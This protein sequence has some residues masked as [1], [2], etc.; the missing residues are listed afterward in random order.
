LIVPVIQAGRCVGTLDIESDT[1]GAFGGAEI[2]QYEETAAVLRP[3]W[4]SAQPDEH[5]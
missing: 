5:S 1:V 3:L 2:T 4:A